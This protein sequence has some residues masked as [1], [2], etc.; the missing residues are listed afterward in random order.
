MNST[1]TTSIACG[2][3]GAA[4]IPTSDS[5]ASTSAQ[6][7]TDTFDTRS[8]RKPPPMPP[9]GRIHSERRDEAG[10]RCAESEIAFVQVRGEAV[11]R[12]EH[13]IAAEHDRGDEP[14]RG[15]PRVSSGRSARCPWCA[16]RPLRGRPC[17]TDPSRARAARRARCRKRVQVDDELEAGCIGAARLRHIGEQRD[18]NRR[19]QRLDEAT[20]AVEQA[21]EATLFVSRDHVHALD[22]GGPE[23]EAGGQ[24]QPPKISTSMSNDGPVA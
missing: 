12:P 14:V 17:S 22:H 24:P 18:G 16:S 1:S 10:R 15:S 23:R 4:I 19:E 21:E 5:A 13:L 20:A 7:R 11:G 9:T 6:N 8:P 2:C 3:A